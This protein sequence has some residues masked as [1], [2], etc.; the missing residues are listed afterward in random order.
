L[1]VLIAA[2][3][4]SAIPGIA[5]QSCENLASIKLANVTF[6]TVRAYDAGW[7]LPTTPGPFGTPAG[8][9]V[10]VPFCRIAGYSQPTSDSH[11]GFE[12]W[13]PLAAVGMEIPRS[14]K[15]GFIGSIVFQPEN[16]GQ[17]QLCPHQARASD[18]G[19][20][21][22]VGIR[23]LKDWGYR[24]SAGYQPKVIQDLWCAGEVF[25]WNSCH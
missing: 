3:A 10:S 2:I 1:L 25:Y 22:A 5:Q 21:W 17:E 23:K 15:S 12:V 16:S 8:Q 20:S 14:W 9:R 19:Y 13:L 4:L 6:T 18:A 11:I 7:E 24:A